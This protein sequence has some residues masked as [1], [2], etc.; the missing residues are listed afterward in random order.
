MA[1]DQP[2]TSVVLGE[3]WAYSGIGALVLLKPS[4]ARHETSD[5]PLS[6]SLRITVSRS[7]VLPGDCGLFVGARISLRALAAYGGEAVN[8]L[9]PAR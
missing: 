3:A 4:E 8:W 2:H 5:P 9:K 1:G 7:A 6:L